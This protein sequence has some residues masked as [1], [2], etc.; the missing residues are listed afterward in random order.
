MALGNGAGEA[1]RGGGGGGGGGHWVSSESSGS[2]VASRGRLGGPRGL[3]CACGCASGAWSCRGGTRRRSTADTG[4]VSRPCASAGASTGDRS[5]RRLD[6]RCDT[7]TA[8]GPCAAACAESTYR[9]AR[10]AADTRRTGSPWQRRRRLPRRPLPPPAS[11]AVAAVAAAAAV[12][13]VVIV[14][15]VVVAAAA[16]SAAVGSCDVRSSAWR[17]GRAAPSLDRWRRCGMRPP[18]SC[19]S[20]AASWATVCRSNRRPPTL[21]LPKGTATATGIASAFRR[22]RIVGCSGCGRQRRQRAVRSR[23]C[24]L[25]WPNRP[26]ATRGP[27]ATLGKATNPATT[28]APATA[29]KRNCPSSC[30][31]TS[32]SAKRLTAAA[33]GAPAGSVEPPTNRSILKTQQH[34]NPRLLVAFQVGLVPFIRWRFPCNWRSFE[35]ESWLLNVLVNCL[36]SFGQVVGTHSPTGFLF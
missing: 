5:A 14:V 13:V 29:V 32:A 6:R 3:H 31:S 7:C 10:T 18:C 22:E 30:P 33:V 17:A 21:L 12:V 24:L 28:L 27:P 25:N 15:V 19:R 16:A 36:S 4:R 34:G 2:V 23:D 8:S 1:G 35:C 11:L 26:I 9:C 20:T